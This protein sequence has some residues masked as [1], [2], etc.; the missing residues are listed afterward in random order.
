MGLEWYLG[1][2]FFFLRCSLDLFKERLVPVE[3]ETKLIA[4]E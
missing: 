2:A 1:M 4:G 3:S